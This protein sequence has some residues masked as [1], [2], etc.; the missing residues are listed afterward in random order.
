MQGSTQSMS[1]YRGRALPHVEVDDGVIEELSGLQ[2]HQ[3]CRHNLHRP[4]PTMLRVQ[5]LQALFIRTVMSPSQLCP[6][7]QLHPILD[8]DITHIDSMGALCCSSSFMS[9]PCLA[10]SERAAIDWKYHREEDP[11][12]NVL[13]VVCI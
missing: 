6:A 13:C 8:P 4:R 3:V 10:C 9:L 12:R 1:A 2:A 5:R 11:C 7:I